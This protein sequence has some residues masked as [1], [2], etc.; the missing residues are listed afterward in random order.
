MTHVAYSSIS[1]YKTYLR[2]FLT[3]ENDANY[4]ES[5]FNFCVKAYIE[6]VK[7][8]DNDPMDIY[9]C[10]VSIEFVEFVLDELSNKNFN[11]CMTIV[12]TDRPLTKTH[13]I[14]S[15]EFKHIINGIKSYDNC[16]NKSSTVFNILKRDISTQE[17]FNQIYKLA[18]IVDIYDYQIKRYD[19]ITH[20]Y[21]SRELEKEATEFEL[22]KIKSE[23]TENYNG[24]FKYGCL[25]CFLI[26]LLYAFLMT[27]LDD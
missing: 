2:R 25:L 27:V 8:Y 20:P 21:F 14:I 19:M 1:K 13:M 26:S 6:R 12:L 4:A 17:K 22:K 5:T 16:K 10:C 7:I 15:E 9:E 3:Y 18:T 24:I 23:Q 11:E